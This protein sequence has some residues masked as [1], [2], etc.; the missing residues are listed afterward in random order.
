MAG[1]PSLELL[2]TET[3][4]GL[5]E[6]ERRG[7]NLDTKAGVL[8]GFAG[9]LV[10][11]SVANLHGWPAHAGAAVGA[12]AAVLAGGATLPRSFPTLDLRELRDR[13]LT[14]EEDVTR[15][16]LLDTRIAMFAETRAVLKRKAQLVTAATLS[17]GVAVIVTVV[18]GMVPG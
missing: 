12:L 2:S 5:A 13:Y 10:G 1:L 17:L 18:A 14:A 7:A 4:A 11:L 9:V 8:L 15:L 6:Q 16:T 3:S